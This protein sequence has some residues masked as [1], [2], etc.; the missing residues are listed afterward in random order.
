MPEAAPRSRCLVCKLRKVKC[1][2][3]PEPCANCSR[4]HLEPQCTFIYPSSRA[5]GEPNAMSAC[6]HETGQPTGLHT[7]TDALTEAGT[8]RIRTSA[9]C[10][11]C[12]DKK[13]KCSGHQPQCQRCAQRNLPCQYSMRRSR[14]AAPSQP[15]SPSPLRS[16][17][18][19]S[20]EMDTSGAESSTQSLGTVNVEA[21]RSLLRKDVMFQHIEAYFVY[22]YPL[23]GLDFFHKASLLDDFH[24]DRIPPIL[25]SAICATV[26]MYISRTKEGRA[27]SIEWAK[28]VDHYIV[29]NMNRLRLI[30][31]K[32]LILS[33]F[34]HYAYRQFG[35]VW[36][37]LGAIVRLAL[38]LQLN[39]DQALSQEASS[40]TQEECHRRL[41]WGLFIQDKLLSGGVQQF[42]SLPPDWMHLSLPVNEYSFQHEC[43]VRTGTLADGINHLATC[44]LDSSGFVLILHNLRYRILNFT[45]SLMT[46]N[47]RG[48]NN[49]AVC[50]ATAIET[51][52]GLRQELF[53]FKAL[54]P[55][56]LK[57]S[58]HNILSFSESTEFANF[59]G[60]HIWFFQCCC[61]LFQICLP[62]ATRENAFAQFLSHAPPGFVESWQTLAVSYA[63]CWA[64][65]LKRVQELK[66]SRALVLCGDIIPLNPMA[67]MTAYQCTKILLIARRFGIYMMSLFDP[68]TSEPLSVDEEYLGV[69]CAGNV[70]FLDGPAAATP[71][72]AV[73]Q[74]DIKAMIE[75][76]SRSRSSSVSARDPPPPTACDA[77]KRDLLS[78]YHPL[79]MD[80]EDSRA[81]PDEA[82]CHPLNAPTTRGPFPVSAPAPA[83]VP[84][85]SS[86]SHNSYPRLRPLR[87]DNVP[88]A[89]P[90]PESIP[91][92]QGLLTPE[93]PPLPHGLFHA[94]PESRDEMA[95]IINNDPSHITGEPGFG[96]LDYSP[97]YSV[98]TSQFDIAGELDWFMMGSYISNQQGG[99]DA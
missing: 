5:S 43:R 36:L 48:I 54:L 25:C 30:N 76:E 52:N 53:T 81:E 13:S 88:P 37:M 60:L 42:V 17:S 87:V 33:M 19:Y 77:Q 47:P 20:E 78:R 9:A 83:T 21:D 35:R 24:H 12:R 97:E 75:R 44:G 92:I 34:Q 1:S 18:A 58:D 79:A 59:L 14:P 68:L 57:L 70:S 2:G 45:K 41:M 51:L 29:S 96:S 3:G 80:Y 67:A 71:V 49:Q 74:R 69:L 11:Q 38:A 98:A 73:I 4:L 93:P 40:F 8:A 50:A 95:A 61:D 94:T 46:R 82:Q 84:S 72:T 91:S 32:V 16:S 89:P 85:T 27:L 6:R 63:V 31:L 26:A 66:N 99:G 10:D 62:G 7:P 23:Q 56:N 39:L 15:C 90:A 86:T 28:D 22:I 55:P 65:M 64:K